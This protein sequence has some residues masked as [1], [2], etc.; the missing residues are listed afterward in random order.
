MDKKEITLERKELYK[1]VWKKPMCRLAPEYGISDVAL[2]KICKKLNVPTPPRGY[3]VK[4]EC[5]IKV[6][7]TP[8]PK[9]KYGQPEAHTIQP[10]A[11]QK[12]ILKK[13]YEDSILVPPEI[14][15]AK[16]IIVRKKLRNPHPLVAKTQRILEKAEPDKYGMFRPWQKKY[17][18]I[19]VGP[20]SL[21]RALRIM[22]ALLKFFDEMEFEVSTEVYQVRVYI[23]EVEKRASLKQCSMDFQQKLDGW[24][25]WAKQ[26]AERIDPLSKGLL[27]EIDYHE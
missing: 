26:H 23:K 8:L 24:I 9:K 6:S 4:L 18:N 17:L 20:D 11:S 21:K 5:G 1:Q 2:K 14:A 19:R 12:N 7:K 25:S 22:D 3:W 13:S 16:P 27:F 15:S 10:G